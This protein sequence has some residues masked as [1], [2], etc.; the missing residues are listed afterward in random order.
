MD[1]F[2][3]FDEQAR[4]AVELA[5]DEA[6]RLGH[7]HIG[8]EHLLLGILA[9]GQ[10]PAAQALEMSGATL[11]GCRQKAGEA[12]GITGGGGDLSAKLALT[13]RA[14]RALDRAARLSLR[15]RATHVDNR[16]ILLSVLDVEGTAGQVLRGLSV[17]LNALRASLDAISEEPPAAAADT[18]DAIREPEHRGAPI[19]PTCRSSLAATL[20]QLVVKANQGGGRSR[21]YLVVYCSSCGSAL[22][23]TST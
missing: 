13:D 4:R 9:D 3:R 12:V 18:G 16:H 14:N 2:E 8:T 23:A 20:A 11:E 7:G 21:D 10:S 17:D 15:R 1:V 19:C 5:H 22:G 6:R